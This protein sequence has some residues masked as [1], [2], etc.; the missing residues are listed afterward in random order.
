MSSVIKGVNAPL[1]KLTL[2]DADITQ[3]VEPNLV[4]LSY[5]DYLDGMS[6]ELTVSFYDEGDKWINA[7]WPKQGDLL[8][9]K[10]GY[11]NNVVNFGDFEL[12]EISYDH[13]PSVVTLRALSTGLSK[14]NRTLKAKAYENTTL[15]GI[16]KKVAKR[17]KLKPVG[18]IKEIQLTRV[19][20]YQESDVAFLTRLA[21]EYGHSFKIV[22][23]KLVFTPLDELENQTPVAVL[24]ERDII[25]ISLRDR[26]SAVAKNVKVTGYD[27]KKKRSVSKTVPAKP[28]RKTNQ[29]SA[30]EL[31]IVAKA[32]NAGMMQAKADA[33]ATEQ[34]QDQCAGNI[35]LWGNP[36]LVAGQTV[37]LKNRGN[38][39][40]KYLVNSSRHDVNRHSGYV[41]T[42]EV[43]MIKAEDN[44]ETA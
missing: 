22:K 1:I 38:F 9:L 35:T 44:N 17:M 19:T 42:L 41:T 15:A 6:D 39:S 43:K 29:T 10:L 21:R 28:L 30:D 13:P 27:S 26:I 36:K 40:G 33:L 32:E 12:D 23:D 11:L 31:V 16:V 14:S 8:S 20:Q 34:A 4:A 18:K 5:T 3:A 24:S 37:V 7:W 2:S 25:T